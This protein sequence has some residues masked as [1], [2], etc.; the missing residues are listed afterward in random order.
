MS[1]ANADKI[2]DWFNHGNLDLFINENSCKTRSEFN[3]RL[4]SYEK[5]LST[6]FSTDCL[7]LI[8][9][10]IGEVGNNCFDHNLGFWQDEPGCLFIREKKFCIIADRGQGI[11]NSLQKVYKLSENDKSYISVAFH[12]VI[13]GRAPEKRGNGLKFTRKNLEHCQVNLFCYSDGEIF[14][15][16]NQ[17]QSLPIPEQSFKASGTFTLIYW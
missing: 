11:K 1:Y 16:R 9:S 3:D 14:T 12:K 5:T 2:T 4:L 7:Y 13:T 15:L 6:H 17:N 10:S 8:L